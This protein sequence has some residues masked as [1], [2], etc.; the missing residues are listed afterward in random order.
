MTLE[1]TNQGLQKALAALRK[2][3]Q[4]LKLELKE[5]KMLAVQNDL[6]LNGVIAAY[7]KFKAE[8]IE[9]AIASSTRASW[10][11]SGYSVELFPEGHYRILWDNKIGNK[12]DSLGAIIGVPPCSD[13]EWDDDESIRF[14]DNAIENFQS[15]FEEWKSDYIELLAIN[16]AK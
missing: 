8:A 5:W 14:Y 15:K 1:T 4:Q 3:N 6:F 2:Q 12:Y 13:D 7:K 11:G 9:E 16:T 10:G